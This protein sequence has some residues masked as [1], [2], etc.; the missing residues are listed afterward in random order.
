MAAGGCIEQ[1]RIESFEQLS[2]F[3]ILINCTGLGASIL[4][5][6]DPSLK[7]IRGQVMRVKASW[8]NEVIIDA[9]D[10]GNYIIPKYM[11]YILDIK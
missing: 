11:I 5:K 4:T 1:K 7:P 6:G 9:S 2:D 10:D 3:D 8:V